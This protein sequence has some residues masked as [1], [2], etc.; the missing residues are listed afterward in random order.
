MIEQ[1]GQRI[2]V[3]KGAVRTVAEACG[4]Q[5]SDIDALEAKSSEQA[6]KGYRTLAI[7][8]G[9]ETVHLAYSA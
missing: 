2:R 8:S 3:M 6:E 7:A 4:L 1:Q 9:P 5:P